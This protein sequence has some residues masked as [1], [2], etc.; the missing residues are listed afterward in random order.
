MSAP[1]ATTAGPLRVLVVDDE[2]LARQR[3]QDLLEKQSGIGG[4]DT[5]Q[6]GPAAVEALRTGGVDLVFL[7]VQMPGLTGVEVVREV[8]PENM[9][10]TIFVTAYDQYALQAF[11]VA[12]L[13]YLVKPF[14]DD[15][16]EQAL[17]RAREVIRLRQVGEV[18]GKLMSLLRAEE[19]T[20]PSPS[21]APPSSEYLER[22][23]VESR[24]QIR[25]VP[26]AQ[27]DY[28]TADGP[29]AEL[30]VGGQTHL[31]RERMKTLDRRLDPKRFARIHRST[32]V[33]LQRVA[34]LE[35]FF[36]GDYVVKLHDGTKLKVS[37]GRR[38]VLAE[39][40]G[41]EF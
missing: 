5:C 20:K 25:V 8:G 7:D 11:E 18:T 31:I 39:A 3:L 28:V 38:K 2:P 13:D 40:L 24:G 1:A 29:Y 32:I 26:V 19:P 15:R 27:I 30:H 41:V 35:P 6:S 16:F 37:R 36:H 12:A 34:S 10:A 17:A 9:P 14:D 22:I 33:N 4:V 21:P 23:A